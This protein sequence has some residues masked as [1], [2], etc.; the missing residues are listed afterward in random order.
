MERNIFFT[1]LGLILATVIYNLF[2]INILFL[3]ILLISI[4]TFI[5]FDK[6]SK[7]LLLASL[8][9]VI[10]IF[11]GRAG[12]KFYEPE[13][14]LAIDGQ[15]I[16]FKDY[17]QGYRRLL[18]KDQSKKKFYIAGRNLGDINRGDFVRAEVEI[19]EISENK[20]FNLPSIKA[21]YQ[22]EN[23]WGSSKALAIEK[24]KNT[25]LLSSI[26]YK[27]TSKIDDSIEDNLSIENAPI[28][29]K[30]VLADSSDL[31]EDTRQAYSDA[32][33]SHLLAIS[34]MHIYILIFC[35][36]RILKKLNFSY[37]LRFIFLV[38]VLGFYAYI[39][40]FTPSVS[41][42]ILM[43][44]LK[45]VFE[46]TNKKVSNLS[47]VFIS[48]VI[49]LS[50]KPMA[51]FDLGLQ[52]SYLS[53]LG[54]L[55]LNPRLNPK[56]QAGIYGL[57]TI[58]ASVNIMIFP[59]LI[60]NF[61]NFN[62]FSF[63]INLLVSPVL[64]LILILS[65]MAIIFDLLFSLTFIYF[66]VDQTLT[67]TNF[68]LQVFLSAFDF[69]L[70]LYQP[71]LE[72][73]FLYYLSLS[74]LLKKSV[75]K[76]IY[77][78]RAIGY[79]FFALAFTINFYNLL[80]PK[81]RL[82]FFDVGQG[83]SAYLSYKNTYIQIDTGGATFSSYNPGIEVT[84]KAIKKRGIR[85]IDLLILSH[86][87][88]DHVLGSR[89][90]IEEGLVKAVLVNAPEDDEPLYKDIVNTG[91]SIYYPSERLIIDKDFYLEFLN[92]DISN[93]RESNDRSLVVL[94]NFKGKKIL[95]T[96]DIGENIEKKLM[97]QFGPVD[98]LKVSHHGSKYS[99]TMDFLRETRPKYSIISVGTKN[100]YGHPDTTVLKNLSYI[101]SKTI[102]TDQEGEIVFE[103]GDGI[104]Y[105]TA[106]SNKLSVS[107]FESWG[108]FA[109]IFIYSLYYIKEKE[110]AND[111][112]RF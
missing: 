91:V 68:Y 40:D 51:I 80:N 5:N 47:I 43:Y 56:N 48:L 60:Y 45:G 59:I 25:K 6:S 8:V 36:D 11:L 19:T 62:I 69:Y 10:N 31:D 94:A 66:L 104:S 77:Q 44:F 50:L 53:V 85:K 33:L 96:G 28:V 41:R 1:L 71:S 52:L 23:I 110:E 26:K 103:L 46:L 87:D 70:R 111:L 27:L 100:S 16:D 86:F 98:I 72:H 61:N 17:D 32:G 49:I 78:Y 65:Y 7:F 81:L 34:G 64:M 9:V 35:L 82:G 14:V 2:G 73:V 105:T 101:N 93:S 99:T 12:A 22:R 24:Y 21:Y 97:G 75:H 20:N 37:N 89:S 42:A 54:I 30:L 39:L 109:I 102:R 57:F 92:T 4:F 38:T 108:F 88:A 58:Y 13:T 15:V 18:V 74:V 84:K 55:L 83:D 76:K 107:T 95:F 3:Y 106:R 112:Q 29:K 90:L 67:A 63:I 79:L